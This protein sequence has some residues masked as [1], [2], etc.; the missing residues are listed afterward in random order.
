M[1]IYDMK[2]S[3][4]YKEELFGNFGRRINLSQWALLFRITSGQNI[5]TKNG[6]LLNISFIPFQ[7][8]GE[9]STGGPLKKVLK[10][11]LNIRVCN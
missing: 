10:C 4:R 3:M 6:K 2:K 11:F 5:A 7:R 1:L 8:A 9:T